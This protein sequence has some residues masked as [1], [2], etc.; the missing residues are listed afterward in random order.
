VRRSVLFPVSHLS[1]AKKNICSVPADWT[2][3]TYSRHS[4]HDG[5]HFHLSYA[6]VHRHEEKNVVNWLRR[7]DS[8]R[9]PSVVQVFI[10]PEVIRPNVT[11]RQCA[12]GSMNSGLSYRVGPYLARKVRVGEMWALV[13]LSHINN[14]RED[15][16]D[17]FFDAT[18]GAAEAA[19]ELRLGSLA[20][21]VLQV[22][23]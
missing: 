16:D 5:S 1:M 10:V 19:E 13:M 17:N 20:M 22:Q 23:T 8:R 12:T 4:C 3:A 14:R 18:A 21:P 7:S 9:Q 6:E 2:L 15:R 11:S